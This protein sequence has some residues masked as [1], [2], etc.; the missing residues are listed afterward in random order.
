MAGKEEGA[1]SVA[2]VR[3]A[4][5]FVGVRREGKSA[6]DHAALASWIHVQRRRAE[7]RCRAPAGTLSARVIPEEEAGSSRRPTE[8]RGTTAVVGKLT[9]RLSP[10]EASS[11]ASAVGKS[12]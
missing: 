1:S 9:A 12:Q 2:A 10:S 5:R 6:I 4:T 7:S 8:R 3:I 11:Q